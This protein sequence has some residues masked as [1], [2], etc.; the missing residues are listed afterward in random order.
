M[1]RTPEN[2]LELVWN[3]GECAAIRLDRPAVMGILN[4]TPD[5]FSDG[6]RYPDPAAAA[7]AA[8]G[9]FQAGAAIVD[10]GGESTRPGA[11]RVAADEQTRRVGPV[12]KKI[13]LDPRFNPAWVLSI[14]TTWAE[15]AGAAIDLG[16]T[17]INDV[18]AGTEDEGML[19]LAGATKSGLML[20]HRLAPP[21][22]DRYSDRYETPPV[23]GDV[24]ASV[25]EYLA[26]RM[27]AAVGAGVSIERIALDPGLGFGKTVEQNL[28]LIARTTELATLGRPVVSALSRKSFVARASGLG[29]ESTPDQR[30]AGTL[31]LTV[32]HR[33]RGASI[34]RVHDVAGAVRALAAVQA[35]GVGP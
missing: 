1:T 11:E 4:V 6:G 27:A 2:P 10:V 30:E 18:S 35:A 28:A 8:I 9:M 15:V 19:A 12:L 31:A 20:M 34:F 13:T 7:E 17:V 32:V 14:D 23:Y 25:R 21:G 33:L 5:S 29:S 22:S 26:A 24:V 16:A 3:V